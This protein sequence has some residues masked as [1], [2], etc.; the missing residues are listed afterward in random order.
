MVRLNR[1]A[2]ASTLLTVALALLGAPALAGPSGWTSNG[3]T[4]QG[5]LWRLALDPTRNAT[6][7]AA[8]ANGSGSAWTPRVFRSIDVGATWQELTNGIVNIQVGTLTVDPTNGTTIYVG[9]YNPV[10]HSLALY[11]STNSGTNWTLLAWPFSAAD[12]DRPVLAV[13]VDP[14]ASRTLYVGTST[15]LLKSTDQGDSWT[16]LGGGLPSAAVRAIVVDRT[17]GNNVYVAS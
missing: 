10:A 14:T 9:G 11:K 8:G 2:L 4:V 5:I 6:I 17:N 3:P 1:L 13:T 16:V 7:Y 15:G 12:L